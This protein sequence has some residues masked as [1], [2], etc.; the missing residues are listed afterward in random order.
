MSLKVVLWSH[1]SRFLAASLTREVVTWLRKEFYWH[2]IV[3]GNRHHPNDRNNKSPSV[4]ISPTHPPLQIDSDCRQVSC[5]FD[6]N[7]FHEDTPDQLGITLP[8]SLSR[9]V[10]KRKAEF[11]AGRYCA[12]EALARLGGNID[13]TNGTSTDADA[14]IG[15]GANREPLWPSRFIGSITHTHGYACA[16]VAC[17]TKVRA[18]GIDSET[19]IAADSVDGLTRHILTPTE[20]QADRS[21]M[22]ESPL[23]YLTMVF[24]AKESLFKCLFP[25]VNK[26]FD[27]HAAVI[28]PQQSRST[29]D[30]E[31]RFELLK[32]LND[33]FCAGYSGHGSYSVR[34]DF[35]HTGIVL[36]AL[37]RIEER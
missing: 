8:P 33:E 27:F 31:F 1:R 21:D 34:A 32:D 17:R 28:T 6:K 10:K 14:A 12:R 18:V 30:G 36:K 2:V 23:H 25:L 9:A 11:I 15:I 26:F 37:G 16:V 35:V 7:L 5:H 3:Q 20:A 13:P 22:F 29:A 4:V 24:S 19:W